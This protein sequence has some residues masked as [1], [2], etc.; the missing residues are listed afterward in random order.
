ME[1]IK[2]FMKRQ[3]ANMELRKAFKNAGILLINIRMVIK[4]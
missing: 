3:K 2:T 4:N 1:L